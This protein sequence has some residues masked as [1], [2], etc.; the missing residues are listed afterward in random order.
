[1]SDATKTLNIGF[2]ATKTLVVDMSSLYDITPTALEFA[3]YR[4]LHAGDDYDHD[5]IAQ[6]TAGS[7][8]SLTKVWLTIKHSTKDLDVDA[9]LQVDSDTPAQLEITDGPNGEFTVH[10]LAADTED[11]EGPWF[12]DIQVLSTGELKTVA[13]GTI[14]FLPN[15]TRALS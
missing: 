4:P 7:P 12:Y 1:M 15:I 13:R 10:F 2:S 11:L 5:F 8:L 3:G 9:K 6:A 14:E